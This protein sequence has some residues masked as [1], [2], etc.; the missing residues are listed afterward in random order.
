M[1]QVTKLYAELNNLKKLGSITN[2]DMSRIILIMERLK[3]NKNV[4]YYSVDLI[5][6]N[7]ETH[8]GEINISFWTD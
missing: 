4:K 3:E 6:F 7:Q 2:T 1:K 8:A 5:L